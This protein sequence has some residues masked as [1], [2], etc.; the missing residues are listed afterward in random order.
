VRYIDDLITPNNPDFQAYIH[1]IYT[2]ELT[3][4]TESQDSLFL[5]SWILTLNSH[6]VNLIHLHVYLTSSEI[7]NLPY[8]DS[9]IHMYIPNSCIIK[10]HSTYCNIQLLRMIQF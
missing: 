3:T 9:N 6:M 7:D 8:M 2:L 1:Q 10:A 5:H 4:M